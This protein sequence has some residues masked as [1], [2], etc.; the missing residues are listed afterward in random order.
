M[1]KLSD[2]QAVLLAAAAARPELTVLPGPETLKLRG[3]TLE[4]SLQALL[5][6][7]FIAQEVDAGGRS[8]LVATP[9]GLGAIGVETSRAGACLNDTVTEPRTDTRAPKAPPG[10]KLGVLLDAVSRPE[11]ATL[12]ELSAAAGWLPHTT[13]AA[14]S[15]LR[16]RGYAVRIT[17]TGTRKVYQLIPAV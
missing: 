4:R 14:I 9:A 16:Q 12:E 15:R 6:S 7:G 11:G 1:P 10:G 13:R 2:T 17:M 8:R 3:A 5:R